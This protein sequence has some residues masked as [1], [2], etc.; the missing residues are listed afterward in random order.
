MNCYKYVE[1][2][3]A[4]K[5]PVCS[6]ENIGK[7]SVKQNICDY[8]KRN[9]L[10]YVNDNESIEE[11]DRMNRETISNIVT[12]FSSDLE[13]YFDGRYKN[14]YAIV[15]GILISSK[16]YKATAYRKTMD[17]F[18]VR[19]FAKDYLS[20]SVFAL[21]RYIPTM[22]DRMQSMINFANESGDYSTE[23]FLIE[24]NHN[25]KLV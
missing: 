15:R 14:S 12:K 3:E 9:F 2:G 10:D 7:T 8:Y 1:K 6:Y 19:A 20:E 16:V 18:H 22:Q 4:V 5:V 21:W 24:M 17:A 13:Y 11:L 25:C 23:N